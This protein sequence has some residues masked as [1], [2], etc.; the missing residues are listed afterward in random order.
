MNDVPGKQIKVVGR[1]R[2]MTTP[3]EWYACA[4][5]QYGAAILMSPFP[6]PRGFVFKC[7][8][9]QQW[10]EWRRNHPNPWLW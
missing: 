1:G 7:R 2:P 4:A 10:E 5:R 6:R 9:W 8:T 3:A